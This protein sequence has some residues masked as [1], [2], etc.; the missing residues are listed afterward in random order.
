MARDNQRYDA[1]GQG[2]VFKG[3]GVAMDAQGNLAFAEAG[4]CVTLLG[5]KDCRS[6]RGMRL[7]FVTRITLN[8]LRHWPNKLP[9]N[10]R[11]YPSDIS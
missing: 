1:D 9:G 11:I 10:A 3:E 7:W 5:V 2:N 8:R 4:H 6:I